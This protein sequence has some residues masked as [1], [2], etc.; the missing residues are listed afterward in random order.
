MEV[1]KL[2]EL[3]NLDG[4]ECIIIGTLYKHQQWK[5]SIL[6]EL[7]EDHQLAAPCVRPDYCSE[8]DQPFLEDEMLRIKLVGEKVDLKYI[9][10]G[11]VCAILGNEKSDG[12]FQVILIKKIILKILILLYLTHIIHLHLGKRLVLSRMCTKTIYKRMHIKWKISNS[13]RV[14][15]V[16]EL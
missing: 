15:S 3:E 11:V 2:A 6:R 10:T 14:R 7:S 4:K 1:A 13:F 9:V 8:K 12:T 16:Q 5:P